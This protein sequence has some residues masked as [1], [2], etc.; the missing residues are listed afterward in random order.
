M[1]KFRLGIAVAGALAVFAGLA[2]SPAHASANLLSNGSFED[3]I[4][5]GGFVTVGSPGSMGAWSV[6]SGSIDHIGSYWQAADG[7][8]S[9]DMSGNSDGKISQTVNTSAGLQYELSWWEAGNNDG[10]NVV[11]HLDA[12]I[13][14]SVVADGAF[15][16][17]GHTKSDMGWTE[18]TYDFI[19]VGGPTKISFQGTEGNPYGAA[20]DNVSLKAVP[21][22]STVITFALLMVGGL[23]VLSKRSAQAI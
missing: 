5:G 9:V 1:T 2:A 17:T 16:V 23:I 12:L 18:F 20:L 19:S 11:K 6:D 3:P 8:Q 14:D 10:G 4:V 15:D 7:N 13:N 22:A 21:E